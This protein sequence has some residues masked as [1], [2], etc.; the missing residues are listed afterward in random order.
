MSAGRANDGTADDA[1]SESLD[2]EPRQ[3]IERVS[4]RRARLTAVA[5]TDPEPHEVTDDS[6]SEPAGGSGANDARMRQD[7]PPHY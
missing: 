3:R 6:P 5:G 4:S 7:V 1:V 2:T